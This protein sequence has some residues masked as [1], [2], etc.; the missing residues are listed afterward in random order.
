MGDQNDKITAE[1]LVNALKSV[2]EEQGEGNKG[3]QKRRGVPTAD[4]ELAF[5]VL[6]V[7]MASCDQNFEQKEYIMI[8]SALKRLF[9]TPKDRVQ[10][11]VNQ[12]N[13]IMNNL[14]GTSRYAA[15]LRDNLDL[16]EKKV[17]METVDELI[18]SDGEEGGFERYLRTKLAD[19]LGVSAD[20][21]SDAVK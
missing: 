13:T 8:G 3:K 17:L 5:A 7:D 4:L 18:F 1:A 21:P 11:L 2:F 12:A 20:L 6:L 15:L 9:G 14:R 19:L 10:T 16:D